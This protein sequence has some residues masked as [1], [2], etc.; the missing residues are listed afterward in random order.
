MRLSSTKADF[1]V[2][3][4]FAPCLLRPLQRSVATG[5][6]EEREMEAQG[7]YHRRAV[8]EYLKV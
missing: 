4:L 2:A 5:S 3:Y 6:P 8:N 1:G 7:T